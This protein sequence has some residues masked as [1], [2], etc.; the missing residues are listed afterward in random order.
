M[1]VPVARGLY[2]YKSR[3]SRSRRGPGCAPAAGSIRDVQLLIA[4]LR[5]P[6][7][8]L[9]LRGLLLRHALLLIQVFPVLVHS[10]CLPVHQRLLILPCQ[11]LALRPVCSCCLCACCACW[12]CFF[13]CCCSLPFCSLPGW[14]PCC[15]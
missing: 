11:A 13:A 10:L 4:I 3:P 12:A 14:S 1:G 8:P 6:V 2:K 15:G 7:L 9:E 5:L